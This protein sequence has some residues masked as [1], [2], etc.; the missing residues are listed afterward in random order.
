MTG[1]RGEEAIIGNATSRL[2]E[3]GKLWSINAV[4]D[5]AIIHPAPFAAVGLKSPAVVSTIGNDRELQP[6]L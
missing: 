3:K 1:C 2:P 5:A 6:F 4:M